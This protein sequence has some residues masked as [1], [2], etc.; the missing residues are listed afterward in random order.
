MVTI[1][2]TMDIWRVDLRSAEWFDRPR[3]NLDI[4]SSYRIQN[5]A[6]IFGGV[7]LRCVAMG[8]ADAQELQLWVMRCY[9]NGKDV[10]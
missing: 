1:A 3:I 9:E 6:G 8:R 5:S 10:L 2:C 4:C 7:K